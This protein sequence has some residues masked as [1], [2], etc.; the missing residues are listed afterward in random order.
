M[1][2]LQN[3]HLHTDVPSVVRGE[4]LESKTV[5]TSGATFLDLVREVRIHDSE[6]AA[7]GGRPLEF[8]EMVEFKTAVQPRTGRPPRVA[9]DEGVYRPA[10]SDQRAQ[11]TVSGWL[12]GEVENGS[13]PL[14]GAAVPFRTAN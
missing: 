6:F 1:S 8:G 7:F 10:R 12:D 4:V 13:A 3:L 14:S 2:A 11:L 9:V 5:D